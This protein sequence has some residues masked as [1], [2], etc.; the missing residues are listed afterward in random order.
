MES[1]WGFRFPICEVRGRPG[2]LTGPLSP[3]GWALG[4]HKGHQEQ[5]VGRRGVL[6]GQTRCVGSIRGPWAWP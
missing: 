2:G 6:G 4:D 3:D 5:R 1:L